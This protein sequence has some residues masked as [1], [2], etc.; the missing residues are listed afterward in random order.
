[1]YLEADFRWIRTLAKNPSNAPCFLGDTLCLEDASCGC[2]VPLT[3][4][5][6]WFT[7]V[8]AYDN[9]QFS[10]IKLATCPINKADQPGCIRANVKQV[11]WIK[12]GT[13]FDI[14]TLQCPTWKKIFNFVLLYP[15]ND[16]CYKYL[17]YRVIARKKNVMY[18]LDYSFQL[19]GPRFN[20]F[21]IYFFQQTKWM[22]KSIEYLNSFWS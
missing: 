20:P 1:M 2:K 22:R 3:L 4:T 16:E 7:Y 13:R 10:A 14:S 21:P 6:S 18:W 12:C 17:S 8:W 9:I 11:Q 15:H 5:T 19:K